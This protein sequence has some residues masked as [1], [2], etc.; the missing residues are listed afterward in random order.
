MLLTAPFSELC[1]QDSKEL[2]VGT[3]PSILLT[4][5]MADLKDIMTLDELTSGDEGLATESDNVP[6]PGP[7]P[8]DG[9]LSLLL[10]AGALYGV[11]RVRSRE[12][13]D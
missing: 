11:R 3:D 1:A 5:G 2:H 10:A 6:S 7:L 12:R 13:C 8:V 4:D 9:G